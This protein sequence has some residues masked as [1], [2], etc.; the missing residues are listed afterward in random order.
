LNNSPFTA[1]DHVQLA[2][3]DGKED[4]VRAFYG[5]LLGMVEV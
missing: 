4:A 1:I 2:M 5:G 3:P